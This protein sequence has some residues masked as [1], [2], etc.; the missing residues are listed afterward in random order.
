[1]I[2]K[3]VGYDAHGKKVK[4]RIEASDE[5]EAK[6]KLKS[7]G[8][9]YES[10]TQSGDSFLKK[11]K[12]QRTHTLPAKRLAQFSKNI[13]IY[14]RSGIPI[15]NVVKLAKSQY[16]ED[17]VM[18][19]F[20]SS[21]E[22][23]MNEGNSY[24]HALDAQN[25]I[26]LPAFYKQSIKVAEESGSMSEVLFEMARF[27]EEQDKVAGQVKQALIYPVIIVVISIF[28]VAFMLT[29]VVPK[30]TA[31][32]DQLKQELPGITK[33]VISMGDFLS[34]NWLVIAIAIMIASGL[35][36]Y[37]LKN[38]ESFKYKYHGFVL[39]LPIFG[40]IIQ[41]FE[42]A[43][44][45]YI[46]SVLVRSGV[47]FVHAVKLSSGILDNVVMRKEFEL[48]SKEVV[49]GK[50]FS[51]ALS[52]YG[53]NV[54]NSFIQAIA[55]GEETSEVALVMEN[56][57]DL[58]FS[59]NKAKIDIFLAILSPILILFVGGMIGFI[60]IAMLLPIFSMNMGGM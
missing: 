55:L 49:E 52:K 23:S 32:F 31:M 21:L 4:A 18:V 1:M 39:S 5:A 45:S 20:L 60:V 14:L 38:S 3:Y 51:T 36:S 47:T 27:V 28:M 34:A 59:E 30:I 33:F 37:F 15:V 19:D 24:Y 22:T 58:Y 2:Y 26:E 7:K 42:L 43:R 48:A 46:T 57:A 6:R 41:T 54:D 35:F 12:F 56:L 17:G 50:K 44:F 40:Q 13:A 16:E 11:F 10:V 53:K 29:T 8:I 9:L 25:I